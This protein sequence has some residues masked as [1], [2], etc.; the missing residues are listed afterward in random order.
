MHATYA[1]TPYGGIGARLAGVHTEQMRC[2]CGT[3]FE[4]RFQTYFATIRIA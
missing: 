4:H 1:E 2:D 3:Q